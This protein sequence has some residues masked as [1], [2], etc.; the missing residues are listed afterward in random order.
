M[1]PAVVPEWRHT[2]EQSSFSLRDVSLVGGG[3]GKAAA[4]NVSW[5]TNIKAKNH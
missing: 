4:E 5:G 3:K 1:R 2:E